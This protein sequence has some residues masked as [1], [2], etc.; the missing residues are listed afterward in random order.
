MNVEAKL[1]QDV[2][3]P[4]KDSHIV[5]RHE[6]CRDRCTRRSCLVV[7]PAGVYS[8][9]Q[10]RD[11]LHVEFEGCLECGSCMIACRHGALEWRY[12]RAG[13]GVQ[14]RFG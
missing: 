7:C 12:P 6:V 10:E 13:F 8:W 3:K 11:Q 14:F 2:F 5:V 9:N 1:G 4:D